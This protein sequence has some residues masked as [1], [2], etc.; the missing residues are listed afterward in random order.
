MSGFVDQAD[1]IIVGSGCIGNST[2]FY[3]AKEGLKVIVLERGQLS[4]FASVRNGAMNKLTR[5]GIGE[6]SLGAYGA[7]EVWPQ[8]A[9]MT[10]ID[11]AYEQTGGYRIIMDEDDL[12]MTLKFEEFATKEGL[13]FENMSGKQL[14]E[15][16]PEFSDRIYAAIRCEEEARANPLRVTLGF[17]AAALRLG[18]VFYPGQEVERIE[19]KQ[20]KAYAVVTTDGNRYEAPKILVAANYYSRK[21]LDTVGIDIPLYSFY[22]EIFVTEKLPPILDEIFVGS[23]YGQQTRE[24]TFVFG[25]SDGYCSYPDRNRYLQNYQSVGRLASLAKGLVDLFPCLAKAK[26]VR[27]WGGWMAISPD[28]SMVIGKIDPI[29]GLYVATGFSGHGFGVSAPTGKVLSEVIAEKK[30]GCDISNLKYDRFEKEMDVFTRTDRNRY[31][32]NSE[33]MAVVW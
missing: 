16:V 14:R 24:G 9:E 13:H 32:V 33:Q 23:Y 6:L 7:R 12:Q 8:V 28:D 11:M 10:G 3:L 15:R 30:V 4:D 25:A 18:A 22:E 27:S 1:V 21:I 26:I 31:N 5:R 17:Y 19:L 20:G 2:A 29:P